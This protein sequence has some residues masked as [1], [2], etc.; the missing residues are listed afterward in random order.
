MIPA[1]KAPIVLVHGVLGYSEFRMGPLTLV[2]YFSGASELL[3]S[4]GNRVL[5][6]WLSPTA[7]V[8]ARAAQLRT[9]LER[10][11]PNEHVHLIAHSMGGLDSRY[12][13]TRL[14]MAKRVLTLTTIAT[15]H[16]GSSFADWCVSRFGRVFKPLLEWFDMPAE[17]FFDLTTE[18]CRQFNE[19]VPDDD[20]VRYFSV[21]GKHDGRFNTP[22]WLLPYHI[23]LSAEGPN[24][25]I[26]SVAS[27][28]YG[29]NIDIWE[30][31]HV[32]L[33]SWNNRIAQARKNI[34][35]RTADYARLLQRLA[36][37]GF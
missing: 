22:E 24:D 33:V 16:R 21:A 35:D 18:R 7:G 19:Q 1:L 34:P 32:S 2:R 29:D 12:M 6:P 26:V 5:L 20:G 13:I 28:T 9:F 14:G 27:A 10:E 17:A 3:R 31:D 25:G 15:P 23:V 37:E 30:G 4:A 8:A 36:D 11:V